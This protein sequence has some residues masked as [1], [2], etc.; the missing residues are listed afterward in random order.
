MSSQVINYG[1]GVQFTSRYGSQDFPPVCHS[2][3]CFGV[4]PPFYH[5]CTGGTFPE[6]KIYHTLPSCLVLANVWFCGV[7][8]RRL[9]GPV[10][11]S[12]TTTYYVRYCNLEMINFVE[13]SMLLLYSPLLAK[14]VCFDVSGILHLSS[15]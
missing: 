9:I 10:C 5:V 3:T 11:I 2:Q 12:A 8:C 6:G 13:V 4:H 15:V 1:L 14:T 7:A